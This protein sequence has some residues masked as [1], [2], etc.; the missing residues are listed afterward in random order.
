[1]DVIITTHF[2]TLIKL[3]NNL[4]NT[5]KLS[6]KYDPIKRKILEF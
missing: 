2:V 5:L 6:Q 4:K 1:L 3:Q